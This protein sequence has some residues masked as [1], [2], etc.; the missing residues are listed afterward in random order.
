MKV[1]P[2]PCQNLVSA[3]FWIGAIFIDLHSLFCLLGTSFANIFSQSVACPF[4]LLMV[5]IK[6][7]LYWMCILYLYIMCFDQIDPQFPTESV[8]P[9]SCTAFPSNFVW[10]FLKNPLNPVSAA[11]MCMGIGQAQQG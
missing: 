6:K 10:S 7:I 3:V 11:C 8:S 2:G 1:L 9:Y 5:P 4:I